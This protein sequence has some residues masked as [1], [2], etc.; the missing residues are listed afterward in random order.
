MP[1][2]DGEKVVIS[3]VVFDLRVNSTSPLESN[4]ILVRKFYENLLSS[5]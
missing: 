2:G 1:C 5:P 3:E 4:L